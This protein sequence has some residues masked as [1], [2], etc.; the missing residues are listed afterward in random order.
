MRAKSQ[1]VC[2]LNPSVISLGWIFGIGLLS[3]ADLI[4]RLATQVSGPTHRTAAAILSD[5]DPA[6][7][8]EATLV[9]VR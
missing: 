3:N 1:I 8:V 5:A 9:P 4:L 6:S 2:W 7:A